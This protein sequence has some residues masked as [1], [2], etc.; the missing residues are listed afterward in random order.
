MTYLL[1]SKDKRSFNI[2]FENYG[3][4]E[5]EISLVEN[6]LGRE[7]SDERGV[8]LEE[9]AEVMDKLSKIFLIKSKMNNKE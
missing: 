5:I 4:L 3:K 9:F 6:I 1:P 2:S 8:S 7:I